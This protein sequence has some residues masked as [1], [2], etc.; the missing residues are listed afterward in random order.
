[1]NSM[2]F[3]VPSV[4]ECM[5][6]PLAKF[7]IFS[8][9]D[10]GYSG[11][12]E[13]LIVNWVHPKTIQ[14]GGKHVSPFADEYWKAAITKVETLEAMNAW[15][16][17]DHTEDMNVLWSTWSFK[18]KRFSDGLLKKLKDWFCV[19]GDQQILGIDFF[20]ISALVIQQNDSFD[21]YSGSFTT[22]EIE[23]R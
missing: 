9:K 3:D 16:V 22:I 7:I 11:S 14:L 21:S 17:V 6:R 5:K 1:M 23:T 20:E 15:E 8:A 12:A 13:D 2:S 18:L 19:R 4:V 10:C